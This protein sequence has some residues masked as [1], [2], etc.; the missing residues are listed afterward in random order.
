MGALKAIPALRM[1]LQDES[2][3]V[4]KTAEIAINQLLSCRIER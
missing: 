2:Y 3:I 4:A 1:A